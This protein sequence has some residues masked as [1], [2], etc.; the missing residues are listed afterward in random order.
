MSTKYTKP[1]ITPG[2]P[3]S[4]FRANIP[5]DF[6]VPSCGIEDVDRAVF[7]LFDEQLPLFFESKGNTERIPVIFATGERAFILRR[8]KPLTDRHG[9]LILPLVS[10]LRSNLSQEKV[11]GGFGVGP[12]NGSQEIFRRKFVDSIDFFNENNAEGLQ[13]Q[14]NLVTADKHVGPSIRGF[15]RNIGGAVIKNDFASPVTEII[16]MSNPRYFSATYEIT[17]WTQYLQQMNGL[18]EAIVTN[19]TNGPSKSFRLE[20]DKGYWFVG[21][22]DP[23]FNGDLNFD[24]MTDA[25][26][27]VKYNFSISVNGYII[28]PEF[29]GSQSTVR[30]TLSAPRIAFDSSINDSTAQQLVAVVSGHPEHHQNQDLES[31]DDPLPG[32][33]IGGTKIPSAGVTGN[34]AGAQAIAGDSGIAGSGGSVT[35]GGT[36]SDVVNP[37]S[38]NDPT[39]TVNKEGFSNVQFTRLERFVDPFTG[40]V[41]FRR[42]LVRTTNSRHGE[43]VHERINIKS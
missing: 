25:E 38:S 2:S 41:T 40:E 26:R 24:S 12:G 14:R 35:I 6:E 28:N 30:R 13:N 32:S 10:I 9:A 16:S 31:V 19:Y 33:G 42:V 34:V 4:M 29:P 11:A 18:I 7:K 20:S 22:V 8:N 3:N 37:P 21:Y 15:R 17:L 23:G 5:E 27:I 36:R 43:K 1:D 39:G